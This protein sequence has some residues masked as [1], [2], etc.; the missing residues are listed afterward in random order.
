MKKKIVVISVLFMLSIFGIVRYIINDD[1]FYE[2]DQNN[3]LNNIISMN[4]EQNLGKGD[5]KQVTRSDWPT[6][7]YS[8]NVT[9]SKCENGS[10]LSWDSVNKTVVFNGNVSDKCY[11]YFDLA[12]FDETCD[13]NT[14]AC[15]I[16]NLYTTV[17]GEN[18]IYYHDSNLVNGTGDN[19]YRY[20]GTTTDAINNYVCFG[21]D[22]SA[23]PDDNLYRIIGVFDE[24]VKLVKNTSSMG[25]CWDDYASP[26][27][28][29]GTLYATLNGTYLT[30][31]GSWGNKIFNATW[32]VGGN[33]SNNLL[34][35]PSM[36]YQSEIINPIDNY[37][38]EAKIGLMYGS[39]FIYAAYPDFTED[40]W[41]KFG[42]NEE[43]L[44]TPVYER[45]TSIEPRNA[46]L[47]GNGGLFTKHKNDPET[48][49]FGYGRPSFYLEKSVLYASG[50]GSSTNPFRIS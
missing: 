48:C 41:L 33:T 20:S 7:G 5:Y 4:L 13:K 31:L 45:S 1:V 6:E 10:S 42:S 36:L 17:Q 43:W 11:V 2:N 25:G 47:A 12:R 39:D 32:I 44:I 16:A 34:G 35:S 3:N 14:F 27:W 29:K 18:Y 30:S 28:N 26:Y 22:A 40:N 15:H 46:L 23:C 49:K 24:R 38:A 8:F 50:S 9:L 19:S 37:T 21:S